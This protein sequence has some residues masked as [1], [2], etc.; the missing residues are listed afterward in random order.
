MIAL[1]LAAA[2]S[3][4]PSGTYEYA[5][6]YHGKSLGTSTVTI[7][8]DAQTV[9]V[10]ESATI[11][12]QHLAS[13]TLLDAATLA[14]RSYDL[15]LGGQHVLGASTNGHLTTF[16]YSGTTTTY[17]TKDAPFSL[18]NDGLV[19][20]TAILPAVLQA[21][22]HNAFAFV[23]TLNPR[24][25]QMSVEPAAA[26][27][28][29]PSLANTDVGIS[30][31]G[32]G[33][34][35]AV[36]YDPATYVVDRFDDATLDW[37]ATLVK[38]S[39]EVSAIAVATATPTPTPY[40][41]PARFAAREVTFR[42]VDGSVLAGTLSYPEHTAKAVPVVVFIGG[43]GMNDRDERIGPN[44]TFAEI[45]QALNAAGYAVLRY[46]KRG[47][48]KSTS[49]TPLT[50]VTRQ[51]YVD[52]V[53]A[54]VRSTRADARIDNRSVYLLGHSEGGELALGAQIQGAHARGLIL[55]AP[56]PVPYADILHAQFRQGLMTRAQLDAMLAMPFMKSWAGVD[57]RSEVTKIHVP[58]LIVHGHEDFQVTDAE[59]REL[60]DAAKKNARSFQYVELAG[61]DHLFI[62]LSHGVAS[63]GAEY[64]QP[65]PVD[66]R[67]LA[68]LTNWLQA[69]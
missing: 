32:D 62:R 49:A 4:P 8:R 5:M 41:W 51:S 14:E 50:M 31:R 2:L 45:A 55:L 47:V 40:P 63:N 59:V 57:P 24:V 26:Q 9:T 20:A 13:K 37:H 60:V 44:P 33:R 11:G 67:L 46:D 30:V 52:D 65:H 48:G 34:A 61:D 15:A 19:S 21:S 1:A 3:M 68:V 27:S 28:R 25:A 64:L 54:A 6:T 35:I 42:S 43:S 69:H 12:S 16:T 38:K 66:Q 53:L 56:L 10:S 22:Q 36:W 39:S 7:A 29:P 58:V 18:V 17:D 23:F